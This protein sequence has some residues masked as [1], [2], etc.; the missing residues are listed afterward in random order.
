MLQFSKRKLFCFRSHTLLLFLLQ[1]NK[2]DEL[3]SRLQ[4]TLGNYEEMKELITTKYHQNLIGIPEQVMSLIPQRKPER[5]LFPEKTSTVVPPSFQNNNHP[6]KPV[7]P[8]SSSAP[9]RGGSSVRFQKVRSRTEPASDLCTKQESLS[10]NQRQ[11]QEQRYKTGET[12]SSKCQKKTES[13]I[14]DD[15]ANE[16]RVSL[17]ELSPLRSTLSSPV[18][19]LSP[20]HSNPCVNSRSHS[21][22]KTSHG[23]KSSPSQDVAAQNRE[24]ETQDNLSATIAAQTFPPTLPSKPSAIQQKPTAYV[25]PMDGQDQAPDESPELKPLPEEYHEPSYEKM[26]DLEANAKAKLSKL[27]IPAEPIEVGEINLFWYS[28]GSDT[29]QVTGCCHC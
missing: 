3:S 1:I 22:S 10:I 17:L 14:D 7:G 27:K 18:G 12:Q 4:D 13:C 26:T 11:G 23:Q 25:R 20:L 28:F 15:I 6:H 16:L 8:L 21:S 2:A 9:S 24:S 19:P 29:P 5:P